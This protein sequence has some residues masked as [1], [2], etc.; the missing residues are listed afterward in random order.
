MKKMTGAMLVLFV[1]FATAV[2]H[3]VQPAPGVAG[4]DVFV[5]Q[6]PAKRSV[7]DAH[8]NFA[9][10]GLGPGSYTL[11]FRAREAKELTRIAD[12]RSRKDPTDAVGVASSYYIKIAGTKRAVN[13]SGITNDKLMTGVDVAIEVGAGAKVQGQVL[14]TGA[15]KM[16]WIPK[17]TGSNIPGHWAD[18]DSAEAKASNLTIHSPED[19]RELKLNANMVDPKDPRNEHPSNNAPR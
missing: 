16:V 4:V 7:T 2:V 19:L 3:G 11:S 6:M 5:K 12:R 13:Q 17:R 10:D 1:A 18:A 8:G 14:A 15:K 9:L